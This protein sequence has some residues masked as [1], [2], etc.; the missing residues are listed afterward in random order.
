MTCETDETIFTGY[1]SFE[2]AP[3]NISGMTVTLSATEL[4]YTGSAQNVTV[5][6]V[7]GLAVSDYDVSGATSGTTVNNYTVTVTGKGNYTG[8]ANAVWKITPKA[9]TISAATATNR[10]YV[11]DDKSVVISGVTFAGASLIKDT[12]YTVTGV[13]DDANAGT[14]KTVNVT[15]VLTNTNYSL[16]TATTTTTVDI[17]K[18]S[19]QTLTRVTL[20]RL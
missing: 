20:W 15:V 11:K 12:D 19:A 4:E 1:T 14:G 10:G 9:I 8:T 3:K 13:M 7:T 6:G 17:A 16:A 2:I 5:T 18:A